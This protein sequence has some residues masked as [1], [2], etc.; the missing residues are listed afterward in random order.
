MRRFNFICLILLFTALTFSGS[1][2]AQIYFDVSGQYSFFKSERPLNIQNDKADFAIRFGIVAYNSENN[3]FKV[4]VELS[5]FSRTF[6]Q[7]FPGERFDYY[8]NGISIMPV[9]TYKVQEKLN[10]EAGVGLVAYNTKIGNTFFDSEIGKGFRGYDVGLMM[11]AS[12]YFAEWF[13]IGTRFTPYFVKMLEY[14]R[15]GDYGEFEK[16]KKDISVQTIEVLV[17]FQF[18]NSM[19]R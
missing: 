1:I 18:L 14:E 16:T 10:L 4:S 19:K 6:Y 9:A 13:S 8:S 15:I 12:Y 11:G 7:E 17:R 5:S 2:S 3:R